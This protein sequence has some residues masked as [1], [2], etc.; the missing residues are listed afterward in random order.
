MDE[1][2]TRIASLVFAR[3]PAI[4]FAACVAELD[5]ALRDVWAD[6]YNL[7]WGH[8]NLV[9]FNV[10]SSRV[11]LAFGDH[12]PARADTSRP[13]AAPVSQQASD[14]LVIAIGLGPLIGRSTQIADHSAALLRVIVDRFQKQFS[15][16]LVLW[17]EIDHVFTPDDFDVLVAH[18]MTALST[19]PPLVRNDPLVVRQPPMSHRFGVPDVERLMLRLEGQ[20]TTR[21]AAN[22]ATAP[23][24]PLQKVSEKAVTTRPIGSLPLAARGNGLVV[25]PAIAN[26]LPD[27]PHP[28]TAE[29]HTIRRA[30][31]PEPAAG[32]Q[33]AP[34]PQR[35][36]VYTLNTTLMLVALPVG[37]AILAYNVLR[38]EDLTASSRAI[39]LSGTLLGLAQTPFCKSLLDLV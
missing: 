36:T 25:V 6:N 24:P 10:D 9:I 23:R 20:I 21:I 29:M 15:A 26:D 31:Y 28:M 39:A 19:N 1:T 12:I 18:S 17:S 2:P 5:A 30:L 38:G 7:F 14:C 3:P 4:N 35:L 32:R 33:R 27:L 37:S 16:D 22:A 8:D 34:L 13:K 11:V